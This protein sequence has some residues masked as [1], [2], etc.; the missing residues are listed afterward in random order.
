MALTQHPGTGGRVGGSD[1]GA[2]EAVLR[3]YLR[4]EGLFLHY[5]L[6]AA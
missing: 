6:I 5:H 1:A 2:E 3:M 4:Q